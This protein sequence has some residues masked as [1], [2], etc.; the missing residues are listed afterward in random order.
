MWTL[1]TDSIGVTMTGGIEGPESPTHALI[2]D[3]I[4]SQDELWT[5]PTKLWTLPTVAS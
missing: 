3:G 2:D 5:L 1:P 4:A